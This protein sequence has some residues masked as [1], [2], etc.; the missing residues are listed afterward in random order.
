MAFANTEDPWIGYL[1]IS[2][3]GGCYAIPI[4]QFLQ[5]GRFGNKIDPRL[6]STTQP[7]A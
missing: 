4:I 2:M 5:D 3:L 6:E 1:I 7:K